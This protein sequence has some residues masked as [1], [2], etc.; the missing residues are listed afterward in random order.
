MW[1]CL[2]DAEVPKSIL[3]ESFIEYL[4]PVEE[5]V[6]REYLKNDCF[7]DENEELL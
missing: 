4:S 7:L 3:L 1:Y 2:F 6:V 5:E